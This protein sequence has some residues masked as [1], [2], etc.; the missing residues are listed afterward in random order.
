MSSSEYR[1]LARRNLE[2]NWGT[3]ILAALIA[4][5]LGGLLVN[6]GNVTL[7]LNLTEDS[8]QFGGYWGLYLDSFATLGMLLSLVQ[9]IFAGVIRQGY[10][11]FLLKQ[12]DKREEPAVNDIFSQFHRFGDG[13]CL[14]LLQ[15]L[16]VALWSLLL[17]IPGII[18]SYRY[19]MAPYILLENPD[20]TAS[21]AITASKALMNGRK[22]ELF[23]L[24]ISFIGWNILSIF[25]LGLL[26]LW[27]NPYRNA[28]DAAFYRHIT[29]HPLNGEAWS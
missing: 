12:Y 5:L 7:N 11:Q 14:A 21:E 28:A 6:G 24:D 25:T 20:M 8:L 23:C 3:S 1:S 16:F 10:A 9:F 27:L 18:A 26:G 19:R 29:R 15:A 4:A 13:F 22:W 2:G 17:V